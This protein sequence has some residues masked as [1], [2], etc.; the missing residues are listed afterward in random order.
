MGAFII[1]L[2][3]EIKVGRA[4]TT[5]MLQYSEE[6]FDQL[7]SIRIDRKKTL[8]H[9]E[10]ISSSPSSNRQSSDRHRHQHPITSRNEMKEAT[11]INA[12]ELPSSGRPLSAPLIKT[13]IWILLNVTYLLHTK[14]G[15]TV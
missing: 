1:F 8:V 6:S 11:M 3:G 15:R 5:S 4:A 14:N 9:Y 10:K 13:Y 12:Y 7:T 2:L